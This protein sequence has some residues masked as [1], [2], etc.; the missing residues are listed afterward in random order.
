MPR[1]RLSMR[2]IRE[3]L[4]LRLEKR[5]S[6]R[7]VGRACGLGRTTVAAYL[8]RF[9]ASGLSWPLPPDLDDETLEALLFPGPPEVADAQRPVPDWADVRQELTLK[10]VTLE[11]LW[12]EYRQENPDGFQ[13]SW[14]CERYREWTGKLDLVMRQ[15]HKPGEKLFVDYAGQTIPVYD[16]RT[17]AARPA[18][19]FVAVLGSSRY[20]YA[21]ATW[22]QSL[23]DW[24]SSHVRAFEFMGGVA[25]IVVPDNLRSAVDR[26]HRYEPEINR[27]YLDL[28]EHYGVA[29][30][31]ARVRKP[32]DKAKAEVGVQL[33][34]RWIIAALRKRMFFSLDEVNAAT[35]ELVGALNDRPFKKLPGSRRSHFEATERSALGALPAERYVYAE[36]KTVRAG[37]DYHV[38]YAQHHYSVPFA[39]V[40]EQ[41]EVRA[42]ANTIEVFSRGKRVASH[43]RSPE[44]G[45]HTTIDEHMPRAHRSYRGW[46]HAK[47]REWIAGVAPETAATAE[48]ILESRGH[49]AQGLRSC[50]GL[51]TLERRYGA[52][53]LEAACRRA[54]KLGV[55]TL[56]SIESIL[57]SGLDACEIVAAADEDEPIQHDNIRGAEYYAADTTSAERSA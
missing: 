10:G 40:K 48:E 26:P 29:V 4:R 38:E 8:Y 15:H 45:G 51:H 32:R 52:D 30:L 25:E 9:G 20:T 11:L 46:T 36:W 12:R 47:V 34:E 28:A 41:V 31:P 57:K 2:S 6:T 14:F 37:M 17:G 21:E 33:V 54:R 19:V 50:A 3:V 27:T 23:W 7:A 42:T 16:R 44:I 22:T 5:L 13:Y 1:E 53:R 35:R 24:T 49:P 18:Q 39:F 56:R 55:N 43:R